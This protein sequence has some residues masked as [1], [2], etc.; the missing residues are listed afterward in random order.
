VPC[1]PNN[2]SRD[3]LLN[4]SDNLVPCDEGVIISSNK[5]DDN[6]VDSTSINIVL[7]EKPLTSSQREKCAQQ[8]TRDTIIY[9]TEKKYPSS[10]TPL[11]Y[12]KNVQSYQQHQSINEQIQQTSVTAIL[13]SQ[14]TSLNGFYN[15]ERENHTE[16]ND[17]T[18]IKSSNKNNI[19]SEDATKNVNSNIT[20]SITNPFFNSTVEDYTAKEIIKGKQINAFV[21]FHHII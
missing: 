13:L 14:D 8:G 2:L 4:S 7:L 17:E 11:L 3:N 1:E 9:E 19:S 21:V 5:N 18:N 12:A 15:S 6:F 20:D 16:N 10:K